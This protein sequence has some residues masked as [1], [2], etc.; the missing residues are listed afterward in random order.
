MTAVNSAM[1]RR[2]RM[3]IDGTLEHPALVVPCSPKKPPRVIIEDPSISKGENPAELLDDALSGYTGTAAN[4]IALFQALETSPEDHTHAATIADTSEP[5][6][7]GE[8]ATIEESTQ[9]AKTH[10][11]RSVSD[12]SSTKRRRW[13]MWGGSKQKKVTG[14]ISD[15]TSADYD[16]PPGTSGTRLRGGK[17]R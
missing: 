6:A 17:A 4:E 5:Q 16:S 1:N 7:I 10:G 13:G 2:R 11:I 8:E 3:F 12:S 9:H 14:Q 15:A